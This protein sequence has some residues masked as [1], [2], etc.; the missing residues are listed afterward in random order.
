MFRRLWTRI[1]TLWMVA[2]NE[3]GTPRELAWAVA[4]GV[5]AGCT[6]AVGVH[7]WVAV[8]LATL[9]RKNRLFAWLGSRISNFVILPW[10]VLLE[11]QLSHRVRTGSFAP[12]TKEHVID[13]AASLLLDW[14]LGSIP[15]GLLLGALLGAV[16]YAF[17][18]WRDRRRREE[19]AAKPPPVHSQAT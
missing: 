14:I 4:L 8:G 5:F 10:I 12:I 18:A 13:Q 3:R 16:E 17:F 6:P 9:F 7:G 1:R 2:K 11:V 15:V 19:E